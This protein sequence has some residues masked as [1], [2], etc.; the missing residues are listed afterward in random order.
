LAGGGKGGSACADHAALDAFLVAAQ[1]G[2]YDPDK[3]LVAA[4]RM[5]ASKKI[6]EAAFLLSRPRDPSHCTDEVISTMRKTADALEGVATFR[7]DLFTAIV[8]CQVGAPVDVLTADLAALDRE[9]DRVGDASRQIQIGLFAA[10][11]ASRRGE[12]SLVETVVKKKGFLELHRKHGPLLPIALLLDHIA[13]NL[14]GGAP[15]IEGTA[16]DLDFLCGM[17]DQPAGPETCKLLRLMRQ[18]GIEPEQRKRVAEDVLKRL[19]PR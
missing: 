9:L 1:G 8:N 16:K 15:D 19:A 4:Q 10:A 7:A 13:S 14:A 11:L 2:K 3:F 6:F 18:D 5:L 12:A 17:N